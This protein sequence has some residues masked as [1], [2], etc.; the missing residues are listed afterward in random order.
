MLGP[1][2]RPPVTRILVATYN[3]YTNTCLGPFACR[4]FSTISKHLASFHVK[5]Q[6]TASTG[7]ISMKG[8]PCRS[9][10]RKWPECYHGFH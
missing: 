5:L 6:E 2:I 8:E 10:E 4:C 1:A 9:V 3:L 7:R